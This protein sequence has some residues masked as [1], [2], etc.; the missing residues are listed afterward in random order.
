MPS[1]GTSDEVY[2][3]PKGDWEVFGP[4]HST[5][6]PDLHARLTADEVGAALLA[7][8]WTFART[9]PQWPHEWVRRQKWEGDLPW[10]NV[11]QYLRDHGR[12]AY[13]GKSRS[14]RHYWSYAGKRYWS[15]G[16]GLS[17]TAIINRDDDVP[18][19]YLTF[20]G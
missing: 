4:D 13:F 2:R 12:V 20:V 16:W 19:P 6:D 5:F 11:V 9:M 7:H 10:E 14:K 1:Q 15:L 17:V 3:G 18:V 8:K